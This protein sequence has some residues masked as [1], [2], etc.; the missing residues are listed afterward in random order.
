MGLDLMWLPGYIIL[1]HVMSLMKNYNHLKLK[2]GRKLEQCGSSYIY[3]ACY[4][5]NEKLQPPEV[6]DWKNTRA[7]C[8]RSLAWKKMRMV[9]IRRIARSWR[10][11]VQNLCL[12]QVLLSAI[13]T[14]HHNYHKK[15]KMREHLCKM[16]DGC[17]FLQQ[18]GTKLLL[19]NIL[20]DVVIVEI[21]Y[22]SETNLSLQY[23][24]CQDVK[25][26]EFRTL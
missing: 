7:V 23:L 17:S 22:N 24:L 10:I 16:L 4:V 26:S 8:T 1:G 9:C 21:Q 13:N 12:G 14:C 18:P 20:Y 25:K 5:T 6:K 11:E 2:L 19:S 3:R 15:N